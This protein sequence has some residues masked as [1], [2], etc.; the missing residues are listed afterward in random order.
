MKMTPKPNFTPRAQQAIN[1]AK[2][3]AKKY[4]NEYITLDH[5]FFGMVNLNAGILSEIL[6]LLQIDQIQLKEKI[7]D[8]LFVMSDQDQ[9]NVDPEENSPV[10]DE[11]F[12]LVL[13]VAA[14]ISEK[15]G[16]EYVGIE[17]ILLALLKYEESNI[18]EYFE[19]FNATENDIIAEV[20]EYLHLSKEHKPNTKS[21][22]KYFTQPAPAKD[23]KLQ[24]LE[25]FATN[26]NNLASQGKFDNIIGKNKEISEVCEILCRRTKNNPVL[27]GDPGVGKTAIVEG[28]AQ[29]I[30]NGSC[31]DFLLNKIIYSLD[32]GS[33]IAGTKY[34]GQFEERLK[35]IIEEAKKNKDI[36]LFIDEI[37]TLVG[38]GSAEGSMDA[39]NLLK[40]LLARGELK[41]IG[42]TTQEEYK[43]SILKDG[44]LDRRFQGV[45]VIEPTKEEAKQIVYGIKNKYEQFHSIHYPDEVLDLVVNLSARY[46]VDKQFPDK[47]IDILDQVGSKVKIK[48]IERP[49]EAKD[50]EK[51]L[52]NLALQESK[53]HLTGARSIELEDKQ[54]DL[55]ERYD[56]VISEWATKTI[57]SKISVRKKDIYEVISARTGIPMSEVSK[58]DSEK[59]LGLFKQ[60]NKKIV[61]QQEA[62]KEISEC[63]L[64][65][66]SG[67]QD[68]S[69]P[70]GSFLLVGASGTGKTYTAKCIA[71]FI[72]G[73]KDKLIQLD[74]SEF[75][76]KIS[77][78]RLIG[79]S[80]GYV[81]YEEGGELTEKVRRNPYS[82][83]LFDEVEKAHPEVL[84]IL[85][86]ILEEGFVTDN[87][88]RKINF[89][90]CTIILTG[91]IGSEKISKPSIGF[92][93]PIGE[94]EAMD[95]L[96]NELKTFF[97]PE[98][99]NRLNEI[100][101]FKN[102]EAKDISK[103]VKIEASKLSDKLKDK[104]IKISITPKVSSF[105]AENAALEK[106]GARP[107][108][109]LIQKHIENKLS[110]LILSKELSD[111][112][113]IK[114]SFAKNEII[115][116]I[117]EAEA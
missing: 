93:A 60:L 33:L 86:Q 23:S 47:A 99:L 6:F 104:N 35:G 29:E 54:L 68:P 102:F 82:V 109:R 20:R 21:R 89:S 42:A 65:S 98:F 111:N 56:E 87:S 97:R 70:V 58:K 85:L 14:S 67:L 84:N 32:L 110:K 10:Y 116:K 72:Y 106:M 36:I 24:N 81:G 11:H 63:I 74:M 50:I 38:A 69:K 8:S 51:E 7:E 59:M 103:I 53:V 94:T 49:Q 105:I 16:H 95:K 117:T 3:V 76:E 80:P 40:P 113:N 2:K 108:K 77:S 52:E 107:V 66:K 45:K 41:C 88:G 15:L 75:S 96:K 46:I 17:H 18:P 83:V 92:G 57:K 9:L 19:S 44:A 1:E 79:A 39:A 27:L 91:N 73:S 64:R 12:H 78:S 115:Y 101:L 43:K 100:I 22:E 114:F 90:N 112:Q 31:C 37:H 61:G 48:N 71:E 4:F 55:L 26:L 13:K 25:K 30:A 62:I 28:L 34:R 5:L